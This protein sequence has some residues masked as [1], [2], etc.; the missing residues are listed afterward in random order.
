MAIFHWPLAAI[1]HT[2]SFRVV[3][4][5]LAP[6][7]TKTWWL[8]GVRPR[9]TSRVHETEKSLFH[10]VA[11]LL[12][13]NLHHRNLAAST[14]RWRRGRNAIWGP[15]W[16]DG[17]NSTNRN[18]NIHQPRDSN[19]KGSPSA[20]HSARCDVSQG[21]DHPVMPQQPRWEVLQRHVCLCCCNF[22]HHLA[23]CCDICFICAWPFLFFSYIFA[24]VWHSKNVFLRLN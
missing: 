21:R 19:G 4:L 7:L 2:S 6:L 20:S 10:D 22:W 3:L 24:F 11:C 8:K 18:I 15:S 12:C 23:C 16:L 1:S 14:F 17:A 9:R 5:W 13:C